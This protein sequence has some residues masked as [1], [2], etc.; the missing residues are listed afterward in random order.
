[1]KKIAQYVGLVAIIVATTFGIKKTDDLIQQAKYEELYNRTLLLYGDKNN[2]GT[3]TSDEIKQFN[4]SVF[5]YGNVHINKENMSYREKIR[6]IEAYKTEK[7]QELK[8][9]YEMKK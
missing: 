5:S 4:K 9:N 3:I 8:N 7:E 1:M 6:K 2:D